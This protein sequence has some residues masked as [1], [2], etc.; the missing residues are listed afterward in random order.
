M[1]KENKEIIIVESDVS[2]KK[3]PKLKKIAHKANAGLTE[4]EAIERH[5]IGEYD[6]KRDEEEGEQEKG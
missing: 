6:R 3:S 2:V 4:A 5:T 1:S